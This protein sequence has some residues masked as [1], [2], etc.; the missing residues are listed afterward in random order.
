MVPIVSQEQQE[1]L[2]QQAGMGL[3]PIPVSPS[4]TSASTPMAEDMSITNAQE[5]QTSE[6]SQLDVQETQTSG[7]SEPTEETPQ[8]RRQKKKGK[9]VSIDEISPRPSYWP[10]V[11]TVS[12]SVLLVGVVTHPIVVGV[13]ALLVIISIMGWMLERR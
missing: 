13:G 5:I 8:E 12:I 9:W 11:L 10:L 2:D 6:E 4:P 3:T 7:E 1:H